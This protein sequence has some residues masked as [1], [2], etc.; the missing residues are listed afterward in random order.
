MRDGPFGALPWTMLEDR[1]EPFDCAR[2][3]AA[4]LE[5]DSVGFAAS[6]EGGTVE[7]KIWFSHDA[8]TLSLYVPRSCFP[9][10]G[11]ERARRALDELLAV[12]PPAAS[13]DAFIDTIWHPF[14]KSGHEFS[15]RAD[16]D[17]A[18]APFDCCYWLVAASE[19]T[20]DVYYRRAALLATPAVLVEERDRR[21]WVQLYASPFDYDTPEAHEQL[22]GA[23]R[24]LSRLFDESL[25]ADVPYDSLAGPLPAPGDLVASIEIGEELAGAMA[26]NLHRGG[27]VNGD[28]EPVLVTAAAGMPDRS[29]DEV[30]IR[31]SYS[32]RGV[33]RVSASTRSRDPRAP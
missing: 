12:T 25:E 14:E 13:G 5:G 26:N 9:V 29:L 6:A 33:S 11:A 27:R 23:R 28:G 21:I 22:R 16:F 30:R 15:D 10:D 18:V 20:Y 17:P 1:F 8:A 32:T 7:A 31:L 3:L 4:A 19:E 24:Y 2:S